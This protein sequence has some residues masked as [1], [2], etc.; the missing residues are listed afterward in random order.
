MDIDKV[1]GQVNKYYEKHGRDE[2]YV[3]VEDS[4]LKINDPYDIYVYARDAQGA[5]IEKCRAA[6]INLGNYKYVVMLGQDVQNAGYAIEEGLSNDVL[7]LKSELKEQ[8]INQLNQLCKNKRTHYCCNGLLVTAE[9][10]DICDR[11]HKFYIDAGTFKMLQKRIDEGKPISPWDLYYA[12]EANNYELVKKILDYG[13][14]EWYWNR[15]EKDRKFNISGTIYTEYMNMALSFPYTT[16]GYEAT[17][18]S[19][20]R[21]LKAIV[22]KG[23]SPVYGLGVSP[24]YNAIV[25]GG[26]E[27]VKYM[28]EELKLPIC[29]EG[30]VY[31]NQKPIYTYSD[32]ATAYILRKKDI[33]EYLLSLGVSV[34]DKF[35]WDSYIIK[36]FGLEEKFKQINIQTDKNNQY[37]CSLRML[38]EITNDAEYLE[39]I[40][41]KKYIA[42]REEVVARKQREKE[43]K[44]A[45]LAYENY[46]E[47]LWEK[48]FSRFTNMDFKFFIEELCEY[49]LG[50]VCEYL[51]NH[52]SKTRLKFLE[53]IYQ[54]QK[55]HICKALSTDDTISTDDASYWRKELNASFNEVYELIKQTKNRQVIEKFESIFIKNE[56]K[57]TYIVESDEDDM[58]F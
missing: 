28:V 4:I 6:I 36:Q 50:S 21:I 7:K 27:N 1:V 31:I 49:S 57:Y 9:G 54:K 15:D 51:K 32:V 44:D 22:E 38:I 34:D 13:K 18:V 24:I 45:K 3:M 56:D 2:N 23:G 25:F 20:V 46:C 42:A 43:E 5:D 19:D 48:P 11:E 26:L 40:N 52:P 35:H 16:L 10:S 47:G 53:T 33:F 17:G 39:L 41:S 55:E 58:P 37:Y 12:V 14:I 30:Q 8:E 29:E